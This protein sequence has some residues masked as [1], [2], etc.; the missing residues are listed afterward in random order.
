MKVSFVDYFSNNIKDRHKYTLFIYTFLFLWPLF[1]KK[2][3][4]YPHW[5][6]YVALFQE[7][8]YKVFININTYLTFTVVQFLI[9]YYFRKQKIFSFILSVVSLKGAIILI[10]DYLWLTRRRF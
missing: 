1:K 2:K 9:L 6:A 5:I 7:N 4:W 3:L 10:I 8:F